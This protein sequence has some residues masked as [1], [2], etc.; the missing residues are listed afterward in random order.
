[1]KI[2]LTDPKTQ[3]ASPSLTIAM[4]SFGVMML[5]V[6]TSLVVLPFTKYCNDLHFDPVAF[7]C[8]TAVTFG[9][10]FARG[11]QGMSPKLPHEDTSNPLSSLPV[12]EKK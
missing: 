4:I 7:T 5:Y 2:F 10:Y 1:M 8:V 3:I 11:I 9:L 6:I 12:V